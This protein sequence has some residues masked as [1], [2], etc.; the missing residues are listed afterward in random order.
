VGRP[1]IDFMNLHFGSKR[2]RYFFILN[3]FTNVPPKTT[4]IILSER[5]RP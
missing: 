5:Y 4:S 1:G 2:F 3:F